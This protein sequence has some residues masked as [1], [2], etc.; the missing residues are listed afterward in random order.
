MCIYIKFQ[1]IHFLSTY[2]VSTARS[3]WNRGNYWKCKKGYKCWFQFSKACTYIYKSCFK[4]NIAQITCFVVIP[5]N[6]LLYSIHTTQY[7]RLFTLVLQKSQS[8]R[9]ILG[10]LFKVEHV[11]K[12]KIQLRLP[13]VGKH[14][15]MV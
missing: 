13:L 4:I 7:L 9:E 12:R 2:A 10:A 5:H 11:K 8:W 6:S 3:V 15:N 1:T 14:C